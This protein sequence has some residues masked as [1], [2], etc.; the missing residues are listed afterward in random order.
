MGI[1]GFGQLLLR[2]ARKEKVISRTGKRLSVGVLQAGV[3]QTNALEI[4]RLNTPILR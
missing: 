4:Q 1:S 2:F 3:F